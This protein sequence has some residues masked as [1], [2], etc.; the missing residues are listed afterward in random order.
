MFNIQQAFNEIAQGD[1]DAIEFL[2]S[3]YLWCHSQDDL[4]D[5]DKPV[6]PALA[7]GLN[8]GLLRVF[9]KNSFFK[10]NE[11]FLWPVI[12]TSALS[13]ISSED[14]KKRDDVLD[15]ITSQVLKSEYCNVFFAVAFC[16]AGFDHA[17]AMSGKYR[18][19]SFDDEPVNKGE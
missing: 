1:A 14:F 15:R 13:Y 6:T 7:V 10:K 12:L 17:L 18:D 2:G 11:D 3:F 9:S 19:Y 4:I 16:V 5:R 8:L